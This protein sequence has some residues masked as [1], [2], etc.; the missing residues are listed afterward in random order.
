MSA[1]TWCES[2]EIDYRSL[3]LSCARARHQRGNIMNVAKADVVRQFL[4]LE[5]SRTKFCRGAI[6]L[7]QNCSNTQ[8]PLPMSAT[9]QIPHSPTR[10]VRRKRIIPAKSSS[11]SASGSAAQRS[12]PVEFRHL[13]GR[14][15]TLS[16]ETYGNSLR[17]SRINT[18]SFRTRFRCHKETTRLLSLLTKKRPAGR[19]HTS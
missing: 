11:G 10:S 4:R 8:E 5:A 2:I 13:C 6:C 3:P 12:T 14:T 18:P 7:T 1:I 9:T 15:S 17:A 16:R 19:G